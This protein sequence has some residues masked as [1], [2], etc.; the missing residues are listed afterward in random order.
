MRRPFSVTLI[1]GLLLLAGAAGIAYHITD[2]KTWHP[3]PYDYFAIFLIRVLAIV[4]G[5]YLL[6]GSNWARWLA[7]LWIAFH[8]GVSFFDSWIT[9][10]I[11]AILLA[12]FAYILLRP[13]AT[14]YF[15]QQKTASA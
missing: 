15:R 5:I 1:A 6:R 9:V 12:V 7:I 11:H 14:A 4:A 10:L 2:V 13:A 3:F 8:V